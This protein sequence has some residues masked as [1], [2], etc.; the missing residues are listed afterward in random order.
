MSRIEESLIDD[1]EKKARAVALRFLRE[2]PEYE[3]LLTFTSE[4]VLEGPVPMVKREKPSQQ[5]GRSKSSEGKEN[6]VKGTAGIVLPSISVFEH[7][8]RRRIAR[9][10]IAYPLFVFV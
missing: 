5:N 8:L 9:I 10:C 6:R 4:E 3:V 2:N 7:R 1:D